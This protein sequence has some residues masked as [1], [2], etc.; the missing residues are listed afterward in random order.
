MKHKN[1]FE[2]LSELHSG[3]T[4]SSS[5]PPP[6]D[7]ADSDFAAQGLDTGSDDPLERF[8]KHNAAWQELQ[9]KRQAEKKA[10]LLKKQQAAELDANRE[11]KELKRESTCFV[12]LVCFTLYLYTM[13]AS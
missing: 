7:S 1:T 5:T 9:S 3:N 10:K 13:C 12:M 4:T 2:K 6:S 11:R 8:N